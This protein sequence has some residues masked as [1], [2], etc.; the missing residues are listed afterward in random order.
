MLYY[1]TGSSIQSYN[2]IIP[3]EGVLEPE[4]MLNSAFGTSI[5]PIGDFNGDGIMDIAVGAPF[6]DLTGVLYILY[7]TKGT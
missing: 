4:Y 7:L 5:A 2:K 6:K 3:G 1:M